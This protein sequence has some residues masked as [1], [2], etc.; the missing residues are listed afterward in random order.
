MYLSNETLSKLFLKSTT[1]T[2]RKQTCAYNY[3]DVICLK[4]N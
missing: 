3:Y 2:I 1:K 4:I